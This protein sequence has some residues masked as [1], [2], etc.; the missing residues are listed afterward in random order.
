MDGSNRVIRVPFAGL[1]R[2]VVGS[3]FSMDDG[4]QMITEN[5]DRIDA[6]VNH[7]KAWMAL[8]ETLEQTG[9]EKVEISCGTLGEVARSVHSSVLE[10]QGMV[11]SIVT[12]Q[13]SAE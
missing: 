1:S 9:E 10:I 4:R 6:Q 11:D 13:Q 7:I 3:V 8:L 5:R 12:V 2:K